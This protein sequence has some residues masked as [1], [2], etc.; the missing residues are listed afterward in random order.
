MVV[1]V[2]TCSSY[3]DSVPNYDKAVIVS[4]DGFANI[5]FGCCFGERFNDYRQLVAWQNFIP[6][7]LLK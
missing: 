1:L 6:N 2:P 4:G 5:L 3:N 7:D